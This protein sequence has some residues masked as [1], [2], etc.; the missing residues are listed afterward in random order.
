MFISLFPKQQPT[1]S[2]RPKELGL[3]IVGKEIKMRVGNEDRH[4]GYVKH[5]PLGINVTR[6]ISAEEYK[7]AMQGMNAKAVGTDVLPLVN[8]GS[9]VVYFYKSMH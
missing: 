7:K 9:I 1:F 5:G 8:E 3:K 2:L 4:I 6:Y